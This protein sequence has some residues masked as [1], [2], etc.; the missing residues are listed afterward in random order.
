MARRFTLS[1]WVDWRQPGGVVSAGAHVVLLVA[2]VVGFNATKPFTP[3][4]EASPVDIV[5]ESQFNEMMKGDQKGEKKPEVQQRADRASEIRKENDPGDAKKDVPADPPKAEVKPEPPPPPPP[6]PPARPQVAAIPPP[7]QRLPELRTRPT[8]P[9]EPEPEEEGEPIKRAAPKP[10]EP[11]RPEPKPPEPDQLQRLLEQKQREEAATRAAEQKRVEDEKRK[12]ETERRQ[13]EARERAAREKAEAERL[14][15]SIRNRLNASREAP[16]STGATA[17]TASQQASLGAPNATGRRLS[18]SD[19]SRLVGILTEQM[20][21]CL[22][23][24][25]GAMPKSTPIINIQL[26][27]DGSITGGPSLSNPRNEPG[28]MPFAE[29]NMR[30]LRACAPYRIPERFLETY[31]DWK[32]LSIGIIPHES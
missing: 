22:S 26:G 21:R 6:L 23:V 13:R 9:P 18:P 7:P 16:A 32:N 11:K 4:E 14:E 10:P 3:A 12:A 24:P 29:A 19:R 5:S 28:F 15:A 2:A 30:A 27:R 31:N 17:P 25:P 8:P 20:N 1:D